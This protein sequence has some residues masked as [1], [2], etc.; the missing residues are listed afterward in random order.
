MSIQS[1]SPTLPPPSENA[2][3]EPQERVRL[4]RRLH[5]GNAIA[6]SILWLVTVIVAVIF[7]AIILNLIWTGLPTML[8]A[9]FYGTGLQGIAPELFNTFYILILTEIFLFPISL[10][11]AIYLVEYARQGRLMTVIHFAAETL[12]GV[13]SLVLGMFGFLVFSSDAHLS[14]SRLAGALTL[15]C[16]NFPLGLR[17]FEDALTVVSRE[18]HEGS[19]ALGATRWR[20]IRSVVLPSALPGIITGLILTAG[21]IIGEAAALIFT[22]GLFNPAN[23]FTLDP[24]LASDTLTTR[25]YYIKGVGAGSTGLTS[26][27]ETALAAGISATLIILLLLINLAARTVGRLVQRKLT[28]A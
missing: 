1:V 7:L 17:L 15:L 9:Q 21:K 28:A 8:T 27:Q 16:L 3:M 22:M 5:R 24:T 12:A 10:G 25:L 23:V 11:A 14:I 19:L 4:V 6:S 18:L 26:V 2:R 20:T 13:P